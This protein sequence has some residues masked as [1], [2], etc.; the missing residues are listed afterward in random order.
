MPIQSRGPE[1]SCFPV[2]RATRMR[3][4]AFVAFASLTA[5]ALAPRLAVAGE[6]DRAMLQGRAAA[7]RFEENRGQAGDSAAFICRADGAT[8]LIC[9]DGVTTRT[10]AVTGK[11]RAGVRDV[12]MSFI[13][14]RADAVR[15]EGAPVSRTHYLKGRDPSAW[16]R[17]VPSFTA[18]RLVSVWDGIDARWHGERGP[19]EYDFVVAPGSDPASIL[20][21]FEGA[22]SVRI[23]A[24]GRLVVEVGGRTLVQDAPVAWQDGDDAASK[25]DAAF[26]VA[27]DGTVAIRVGTYDVTRSLTIDPPTLL[28]RFLGGPGND[29][30][31]AVAERGGSVYVAGSTTQPFGGTPPTGQTD[32]LAVG[33]EDVFVSRLDGAGNVAWTAILGGSANESGLGIAVD[34]TGRAVVVGETSS[35]LLP[36]LPASG[37]AI[38]P[39]GFPATTAPIGPGGNTDA[40]AAVL[41]ADGASIVWAARIGGRSEDAALAVALDSSDRIHLTGRTGR[42]VGIAADFPLANAAQSAYGGGT[43]DADTDAFY[44]RLPSGGG[45]PLVSTYLG[46]RGQ[47]VGTAIAVSADGSARIAGHTRSPDFPAAQNDHGGGATAGLRPTDSIP[48]DAFVARL[49]AAGTSIS[50]TRFIGGEGFEYAHAVVVTATGDAIVG[51]YTD[52]PNLGTP[53]VIQPARRNGDGF[54]SRIPASGGAALFFTYFGGAGSDAVRGLAILPGDT[55]VIA[56]GTTDSSDLP[57]TADAFMSGRGGNGDGFVLRMSDDGESLRYSTYLGGSAADETRAIAG[58]PDRGAIVAG[59]TSSA[60]FPAIAVESGLAGGTDAFVTV[61]PLVG[62]KAPRNLGAQIVSTGTTNGEIQFRVDLTWSDL[63]DNETGFRVRRTDRASSETLALADLG[64]NTSSYSDTTADRRKVYEY[65]V[66][67]LDAQGR[68]ATSNAAVIQTPPFAPAAATG[69]TVTPHGAGAILAWSDNSFDETGFRIERRREGGAFVPVA[70]APT[71]VS[72]FTDAVIAE[73]PETISWR[74]IATNEGGDAAATNVAELLTTPNLGVTVTRGTLRNDDKERGDSFAVRGLFDREESVPFNPA[75]DSMQIEF[76]DP[77]A[78]IRVFVPA[79]DT[80]WRGTGPGRVTWS[81]ARSTVDA[82]GIK[83]E[84]DAARRRFVLSGT[85][86][87]FANPP[88][89]EVWVGLALGEDAGADQTTWAPGKRAGVLSFGRAAK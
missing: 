73:A 17:D 26:A 61:L 3:A 23:D 35:T 4:A 82:R 87:T 51:G 85:R 66:S 78:P 47:D 28:S 86:I 65:R 32:D 36:L 10:A 22:D 20:L 33:D 5:P 43:A 68:E 72:S 41:S 34:S 2:A 89:S 29:R 81:A 25:V 64:A 15:A 45:E 42:A 37:S 1:T 9:A 52:T 88:V 44:M 69:L 70:T 54:I 71:N 46:G 58:H 7:A 12:V 80:G 38:I 57:T 49:P 62:P 6:T 56:A 14:G 74:V 59:S 24:A 67:A 83:I 55:D 63:A 21:R 18:V 39:F 79:N 8:L 77:A 31:L 76:G 60:G 53:N 30:A 13:G 27:A 16:L 75:T 19:V 40:F 11:V 50:H 48:P 84:I